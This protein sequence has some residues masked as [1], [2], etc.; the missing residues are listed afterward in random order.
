M[1]QGVQVIIADAKK[2]LLMQRKD[3]G[4]LDGS[5]GLPGGHVQSKEST[6]EAAIRETQE[7][8]GLTIHTLEFIFTTQEGEW[9]HHFFHAKDWD[10]IPTNKEEHKCSDIRWCSLQSIPQNIT[11]HVQTAIDY[12]LQNA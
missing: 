6:T 4:Y 2:V 1:K 7:E 8:I 3:T 10:G 11:P 9:E 5:Y 12:L